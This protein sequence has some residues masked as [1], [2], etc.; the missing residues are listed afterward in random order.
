[1][2]ILRYFLVAALGLSV[3]YCTHR[4]PA[5]EPTARLTYEDYDSE[6]MPFDQS[7][8]PP[9]TSNKRRSF[10]NWPVDEARLTRGYL[11]NQRKPH[12]G[13]DLAANKNTAIFSAHD[14]VVLYT[15]RDFRGFGKM[16]IIEGENGWA[17]IYAHLNEI[18]VTEGQRVSQGDLVGKM[19]RTGRATGVHLH[20][21]LRKGRGPVDPLLYLPGGALV[22]SD[23]N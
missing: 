10:F 20:F 14:G 1:M 6:A 22:A 12:L 13:I 23:R 19:G 9:P 5:S 4:M 3:S 16:I 21:E 2:G 17:S 15:G 7:P 18:K 11:P 8:P